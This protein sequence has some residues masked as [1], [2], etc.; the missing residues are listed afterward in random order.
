MASPQKTPNT[1]TRQTTDNDDSVLF[2]TGDHTISTAL[3]TLE[4]ENDG[5]LSTTP[6]SPA[7]LFPYSNVVTPSSS[8]QRPL[9]TTNGTCLLS[10][11]PNRLLYGDSDDTDDTLLHTLT[12]STTALSTLESENYRRLYTIPASP[13]SP[14]HSR[15]GT[16]GS[17][18]YG[19]WG[20]NF[21]NQQGV[22]IWSFHFLQPESGSGGNSP[23]GGMRGV[24]ISFEHPS[25]AGEKLKNGT[26]LPKRLPFLRYSYYDGV[27]HVGQCEECTDDQ[28]QN[29]TGGGKERTFRGVIDFVDMFDSTW[30]EYRTFQCEM[31]FDSMFTCVLSGK[32][33]WK[34]DSTNTDG[35]AVV[36]DSNGSPEKNSTSIR[37]GRQELK[38]TYGEGR[39]IYL[40]AALTERF[41]EEEE[42]MVLTERLREEGA[43]DETVELVKLVMMG[44]N[45]ASSP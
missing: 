23:G 6:A 24:Y 42:S 45:P 9:Q 18:S 7:S 3:S 17:G 40:N 32:E 16:C 26:P 22:G 12:I 8:D 31:T 19:P 13:V 33:V 11:G 30:G 38:Q 36:R 15:N 25:C 20:K 41:A 39:H 21:M 43:T 14:S 5:R 44:K 2:S 35:V 10:D 28:E 1:T 37:W 27:T 29:V 4:S 34:K